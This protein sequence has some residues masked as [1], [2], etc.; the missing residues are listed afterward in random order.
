MGATISTLSNILKDLYKGPVQEQLNNDVWVLQNLARGSNIELV[1]NTA[2][3]PLHTQ[4]SKAVGS[5]PEN[6]TLPTAGNQV[7]NRASFDLKYHYGTI[8]VTGPSMAKTK[9]DAGAFLRALES[10]MEGILT[11][12]K[13]DLARQF[14]GDGTGR[15]AQC[16]TTTAAN[17]VVLGSA[18]MVQKGFLHV[19][20]EV[21]IGTQ[22]DVDAVTGG[23]NAARTIT[24]V[25]ETAGTITIDGAA[26]TTTSSH[27]VFRHGSVA[28]GVSYEMDGLQ[29]MLGTAAGTVGGINETGNAFWAPNRITGSTVTMNKFQEAK[30]RIQVKGGAKN[31]SGLLVLTDLSVQNQYANLLQSQVRYV[32]TI[33]LKGGFNVLEHNGVPIFAD[34]LAPWGNI[35]FIDSK[36]LFLVDNDDWFWLDEDGDVLKWTGRDAWTA[37]IARYLNMGTD[38][39]N[40]HTVWSGLTSNGI[41]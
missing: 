6:G 20:M 27:Y 7:Y 38:R 40:V 28:D 14:Y 24:A 1:G 35:Y 9:S 10:E 41:S 37:V 29:K 3:I 32:N 11:D 36:H 25:D 18:E 15:I 26:V 30:N 8:E 2:Y 33:D 17:L 21:I 16:G 19:G 12:L 22:A 31:G 13:Y 23:S 4:R 34:H 5:R 39:R